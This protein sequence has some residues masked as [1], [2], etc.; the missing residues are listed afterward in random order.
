MVK[1]KNKAVSKAQATTNVAAPTRV[2]NGTKPSSLTLD[3][4][5]S[6]YR[7]V[8]KALLALKRKNAAGAGNLNNPD[9]EKIVE[10]AVMRVVHVGQKQHIPPAKVIQMVAGGSDSARSQRSWQPQKALESRTGMLAGSSRL[11]KIG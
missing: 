3:D 1:V 10:Q 11:R 5:T 8:V 6:E 4:F 7:E 9:L 2:E